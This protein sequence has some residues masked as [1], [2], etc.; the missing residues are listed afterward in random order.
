MPELQFVSYF[1]IACC[2]VCNL[3]NSRKHVDWMEADIK[4]WTLLSQVCNF[5]WQ[6]IF[7]CSLM[8][9]GC[10]MQ[11]VAVFNSHVR[12]H[13]HLFDSGSQQLGGRVE[14]EQE[15]E[16]SLHIIQTSTKI[17]TVQLLYV[18]TVSFYCTCDVFW[19]FSLAEKS[20]LDFFYLILF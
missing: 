3:H 10:H 18:R 13:P 20:Y 7:Q 15:Q 1:K 12:L 2:F 5:C 11:F 9:D 16:E 6:L 4:Q 14:K 8:S 19:Y 17:W